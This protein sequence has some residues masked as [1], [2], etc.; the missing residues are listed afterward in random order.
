ML[1]KV[2]QGQRIIT[3]LCHWHILYLENFMFKRNQ[4]NTA[5]GVSLVLLAT[6]ATVN[7]EVASDTATVTVQNAFTIASTDAIDFG[8]LRVTQSGAHTEATPSRTTIN[9]DGSQTATNGD[10][11]SSGS[12]SLL[13]A[14]TPGRI[15]IT[16]AAPNTT[17]TVLIDAAGTGFDGVADDT[18]I[19]GV[20]EIDLVTAGGLA[21]D[22]FIMFVNAAQTRI[23]GGT[24]NGIAYDD[25]ASNMVTDGTGAVGLS[26]GGTLV[27]NFASTESPLDQAY[28]AAYAITVNY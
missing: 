13:T 23:E 28:T 4:I 24:G 12:I 15:D 5:L 9:A 1:L 8:L 7:A 14:G 6:S 17:L 19:D 2:R 11:A 27:W 10:V 21:P 16:A 25:V 18:S 20:N 3:L 22:K 26:F